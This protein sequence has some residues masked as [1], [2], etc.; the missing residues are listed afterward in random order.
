[1]GKA[2]PD[3][4]LDENSF[5]LACGHCSVDL[6]YSPDLG[7]SLLLILG[8]TGLQLESACANWIFDEGCP[9]VC[10]LHRDLHGSLFY[11]FIGKVVPFYSC[12]NCQ[13]MPAVIF[14]HWVGAR[15]RH[16]SKLQ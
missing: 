12:N 6:L 7:A 1:M 15:D 13:H 10:F 11:V 14:V 16:L 4:F 5:V 2:F 8:V 9:K 3:A